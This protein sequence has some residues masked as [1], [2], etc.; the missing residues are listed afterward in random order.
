MSGKADDCD[1]SWRKQMTYNK[2]ENYQPVYALLDNGNI[3]EYDGR[4]SKREDDGYYDN[5]HWEFPGYGNQVYTVT[6][7]GMKNEASYRVGYDDT[8]CA[9][10]RRRR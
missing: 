6:P 3:V 2:N 8:R 5:L 4:S 1:G 7:D 10:F 9:F